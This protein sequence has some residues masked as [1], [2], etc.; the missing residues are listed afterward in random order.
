MQKLIDFARQLLK[1]PSITPYGRECLDLIALRLQK[2]GFACHFL[3]FNEVDNL[4][5]RL[6]SNSPNL[7]FLGHVDVVPIQPG[8]NFDPFEGVVVDDYLIGRGICDMKGSIACFQ[9]ALEDFVKE[10]FSGSISLLLT[11]DEEGEAINGVKQM[12]NWLQEKG[13]KIDAC[14]IGEPSSEKQV[15]DIIKVGRRG[16]LNAH[17]KI[18]GKSGHVAYP[19]KANSPV[20]VM[21]EFLHYLKFHQLDSGYENFDPSQLQC[22]TINTTSLACNMLPDNGEI[23]IN[24]R[25][26][27]N[28]SFA[29]LQKWLEGSLKIILKRYPIPLE[30]QWNFQNSAAPFYSGISDLAKLLKQ[31]VEEHLNFT[32]KF[33]TNGGT[34]DGRF[35]HILCPVAELGLLN[36]SAHQI[37]EKVKI[38]DLYDLYHIYLIFLKI[39][40]Q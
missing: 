33:T 36:T 3:K 28:H 35:M 24:I 40:Y 32:P 23:K 12:V 15:G 34:S 29:S 16:S 11:S 13:E 39:F 9:M 31:S 5:A 21:I 20:E 7:C 30:H 8:W 17:L 25:F 18:Q 1:I 22:T 26:N 4:Y 2:L 14:L 10:S 6:G 37:D 19:E 38:Q 27:P